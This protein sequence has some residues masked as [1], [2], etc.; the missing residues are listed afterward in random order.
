MEACLTATQFRAAMPRDTACLE[1]N[2]TEGSIL[3][4]GEVRQNEG[5]SIRMPESVRIGDLIFQ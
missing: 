3:R 1:A 5:I 2:L 4:R